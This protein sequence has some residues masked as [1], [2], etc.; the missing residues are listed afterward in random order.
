MLPQDTFKAKLPLLLPL[1]G[2]I[3]GSVDL[4]HAPGGAGSGAGGFLALPWQADNS[5]FPFDQGPGSQSDL[6]TG[7]QSG[8]KVATG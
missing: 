6:H 4:G 7:G 2:A 8:G 1:P 5:A 3:P